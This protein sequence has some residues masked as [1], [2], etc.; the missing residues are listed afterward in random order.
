MGVFLNDDQIADLFIGLPHMRGGVSDYD[1]TMPRM[2]L[3]SPH[4][5]GCFSG[6]VRY[7]R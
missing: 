5:W 1:G 3:S 7:R 4:A 2:A 6:Q